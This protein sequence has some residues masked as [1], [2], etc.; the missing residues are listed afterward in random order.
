MPKLNITHKVGRLEK[1]L[2]QLERGDEVSIKDIKAL[3]EPHQIAQLEQAQLVQD[4][5]RKTH[6]RPKTQEQM[7]AIGW[8]TKLQV[9]IEVYKQAITEAKNGM[10][11]GIRELQKKR[12]LN[13][14]KIFMDAF[15]KAGA[16]GMNGTIAGNIA[17]AQN[18]FRQSASIVTKRDK[19]LL[20]MEETIRKHLESKLTDEEKEQLEILREHEKSVNHKKK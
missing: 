2:E 6:K 8:K 10:A 9:R 13:A 12:E 17:L 11:D 4:Q 16:Q 5:L 15:S 14:A 1:R 7:Q 20:A 3:L 18:G 19:E